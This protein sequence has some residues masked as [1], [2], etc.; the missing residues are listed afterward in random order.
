MKFI[1]AALALAA[2]ASPLNAWKLPATGSGALAKELN[3]I[4]DLVP[5]KEVKSIIKDYISQDPQVQAVLKI[6]TSAE[7]VAYVKELEAVPEFKDIATYIQNAGLDIYLMWNAL[8][9]SLNLA[10]IKPLDTYKPVSGKGVKGLLDDLKAVVPLEKITKLFNEK[11]KNSPVVKDLI[12]EASNPKYQKIVETV[13][14]SAHLAKLLAAGQKQGVAQ[15][16]FPLG[17]SVLLSAHVVRSHTISWK[18]RRHKMKF[19]IVALTLLAAASPSTA[20][21]VPAAGSGAL[22]REAQ[23]F[24]DLVPLNDVVEIVRAYI[25][26]DNEI[27]ALL[28]LASSA[29]SVKL[30]KEVEAIRQFKQLAKHIQEAGLDI[31]SLLNKLNKS[32]QLNPIKPLSTYRKITG[33]AKGLI[34]DLRDVVPI[35]ELK[36]L[37]EEKQKSSAV[38]KDLIEELQSPGNVL[39][40]LRV[41]SNPNLAKLQENAHKAGVP[42]DSFGVAYAVVLTAHVVRSN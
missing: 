38:V 29:D 22:A 41:L 10:P 27:Q 34:K 31:Y 25:A 18:S 17:F 24:V 35:N 36:Q 6:V 40:Y 30:I 14:K 7:T 4:V 19:A 20:F 23:E 9:K 26:N 42:N 11:S 21:K 12:K 5:L 13:L 37:L 3:D 1:L 2:I 33:G 28:K 15:Q 8:N 39:L 32:L 16:D